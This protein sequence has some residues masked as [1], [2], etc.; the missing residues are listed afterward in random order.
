LLRQRLAQVLDWYPMLKPLLRRNART[1]SGGEKQM[2][3]LASAM[4]HQPRLLL[5]DEPS[6]G[7]APSLVSKTM[8]RLRELNQ[9]CGTAMLVVEQ[10]VGEVL[11][12]ASRVYVLRTGCV[13][14]SGETVTLRDD[15]ARLAQVF[16]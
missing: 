10:N 14:F 5:L 3:A 7:L 16:L 1:L 2:L 11:R 15:P 13:T 8:G 9:Q 4:M 12:L 6:L